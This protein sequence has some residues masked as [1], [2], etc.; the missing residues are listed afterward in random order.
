MHP[1]SLLR[2]EELQGSHHSLVSLV[3]GVVVGQGEH[4]KAGVDGGLGVGGL[5]VEGGVALVGTAPMHR[6]LQVCEGQVII[7]DD[8]LDVLVDEAVVR[9]PEILD[10]G[11]DVPAEGQHQAAGQGRLHRLGILFRGNQLSGGTTVSLSWNLWGQGRARGAGEEECGQNS[12]QRKKG[13][14]L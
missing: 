3:V 8:G 11:H 4:V 1:L 12:G 14:S 9:H 2:G 5:H 7:L 10:V 6:G 13:K